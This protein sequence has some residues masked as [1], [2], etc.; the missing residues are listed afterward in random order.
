MTSVSKSLHWR[1]A[2]RLLVAWLVLSAIAGSAAYYLEQGRLDDFVSRLVG[3]EASRISARIA[4]KAFESQLDRYLPAIEKTLAESRFVGIRL[5]GAQQKILLE[6][7]NTLDAKVAEDVAAHHHRFLGIS[8]KQARNYWIDE[9]LY[10]QSVQ[11]LSEGKQTYGYLEGI[12]QVDAHV[13]AA[14]IH[15][16]EDVVIA[17]VV[18]VTLTS[19]VLYPVILSLNR[20]TIRL[21][22]D[23]LQTDLDLLQTLGS[24]IAKRDSDTDAHNYRVTLY[25]VKLAEFLNLKRAEIQSLI[26][27]AF[28]HDVGKI[29]I[30]DHILLKPGDLT[31]EETRIMRTHVELGADIVSHSNWLRRS[32]EVVLGHHERFDGKGFPRGARGE[33]IPLIARLFAVVDVFDALTSRRPYKEPIPFD[34]SLRILRA[35]SGSHFDPDIL[36]AFE[37]IAPEYYEQFYLAD[38]RSLQ[39]MLQNVMAKYFLMEIPG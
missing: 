3:T 31:P 28:L 4:P 18:M 12:Y 2:S 5:Y 23:L 25:A 8:G 15:H 9:K 34:E 29:G 19:L 16:I 11:P 17:V 13:T 37:K 38:E 39:A 26:L 30:P 24:A 1:I 20:Q 21:A 35:E 7:W 22:D 6:R 33:Y 27:G 10:I 32:R 14:L 36:A